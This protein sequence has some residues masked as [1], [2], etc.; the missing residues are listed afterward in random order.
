ME[1]SK[2]VQE[3]ELPIHK[4]DTIFNVSK[5][6]KKKKKKFRAKNEMVE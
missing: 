1:V 3:V 4:K 2:M 6:K 5:K